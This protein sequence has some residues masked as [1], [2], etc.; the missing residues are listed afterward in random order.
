MDGRRRQA[1]HSFL[2]DEA[3]NCAGVILGP[4]DEHVSNRRVGDPG[5]VARDPVA[6]VHRT[7]PGLHAARVGA[8][9]GLG[10]S[11][12]ADRFAACQPGKVLLLLLLGPEGMDRQHHQRRL[13]AHHRAKTRIDTLDLARDEAVAHIVEPGTAVLGRNRRAKQSH[14]AHFQ[15][16]RR[17]GLF[18]AKGFEN[19]RQQSTLAVVARCVAQQAFFFAQLRFEQQGVLPAEFHFRCICHGLS[20]CRSLRPGLRHAQSC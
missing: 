14:L 5:L 4:D 2:E 17:I 7:R 6:A 15:I 13:H 19:A 12:A 10:Q 3:A 11:E 18:E 16:N 9:V 8:V 20:F 1:R